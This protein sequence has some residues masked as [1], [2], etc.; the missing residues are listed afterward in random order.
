MIEHQTMC[1]P[2]LSTLQ[3]VTLIVLLGLI[4][5]VTSAQAPQRREHPLIVPPNTLRFG[6]RSLESTLRTDERYGHDGLFQGPRGWVY[7]NYLANPKP[8]QNPNLWPDMRST[9]FIG[10]FA[11]PAGS[12]MTLRGKFPYAR[13][14]QFALY[15][16]E[17]NTFVACGESLRGPDIAPESGSTNPFRVGENR[18][19]ENRDFIIHVLAENP[20][21]DAAGRAINTLYV[22]REGR[23]IQG[24]IRIYLPDQDRDGAGWGL[25]DSPSAEPGLPIYEAKLADGTKLSAEQIVRQFAKPISGET[26]QPMTTEQWQQLVHAKDNDPKQTAETAP[27]RSPPLWEKFWTIAY[28]VVGVFK[29]P[30]ERGKI[31]FE[32]AMEGGGEGPYLVT[33]L[34]RQY[35]TV[36]VMQGKMPTFPDTFAGKDGRGAATMQ[37]DCATLGNLRYFV[38]QSTSLDLRLS[39][40][41]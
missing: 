29:S 25:P 13:F 35:G 34:S 19:A 24:V 32:G 28:S 10:R 21:K 9:Y 7:W 40:Q 15:K 23:D 26:Q 38:K 6:D 20:P 30:E 11:M 4:P 41:I 2:G 36:Y 37:G 39:N 14:F 17:R 3:R 16:F 31:P 1:V 33:Y 27:A 22:G 8:I 18:L 12:S 5:S